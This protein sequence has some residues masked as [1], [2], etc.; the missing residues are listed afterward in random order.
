MFTRFRILFGCTALLG[1]VSLPLFSH[2]QAQ[3]SMQEIQ[4]GPIWRV[5]QKVQQLAFTPPQEGSFPGRGVANGSV[6]T[7]GRMTDAQL[8][9]N[10][11]NFSLSLS[12]PPG[13]GAQ[14]NYSGTY[15]RLQRAGSSNSNSFILDGRIQR[16]ASSANGLKSINTSGSCRIDV[17][18]ALVLNS[19]CN[20]RVT[21]SSTRFHGLEQF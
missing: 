15:T 2:A 5:N 9:F 4:L 17:F 19:S 12:V 21:D 10:R 13:T 16:F 3:S 20:T 18:D 8:N 11:G 1:V 7:R 14:V 6:F